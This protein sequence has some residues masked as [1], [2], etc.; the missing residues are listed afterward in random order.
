MLALVGHEVLLRVRDER[1]MLLEDRARGR[2]RHRRA[3][4]ARRRR[5]RRG[6]RHR[7]RRQPR[8]RPSPGCNRARPLVQM[9]LQPVRV[10]VAL[11]A[12]GDRALVPLL[13]RAT[14][15]LALPPASTGR[16]RR[17]RRGLFRLLRL[18]H[19]LPD[20][21]GVEDRELR[22]EPLF[23]RRRAR[24]EQVRR[25]GGPGARRGR[26]R[27][28]LRRRLGRLGAHDARGAAA[29]GRGARRRRAAHAAGGGDDVV[30]VAAAPAPRG[31]EPRRRRGC[32]EER[33]GQADLRLLGGAERA[34]GVHGGG[35][36]ARDVRVRGVRG[37]AD[38]RRVV[39][40]VEV[41][42]H[43]V[44]VDRAARA[45]QCRAARDTAEGVCARERV[46]VRADADAAGGGVHGERGERGVCGER[47]GGRAPA[48][49]GRHAERV[50]RRR[51]GQRGAEAVVRARHLLLLLLHRRVH[52]HVHLGDL[53]RSLRVVRGR[54]RQ[55]RRQLGRRGVDVLHAERRL[56]LLLLLRVRRCGLVILHLSLWRHRHLHL[57]LLL[58][59]LRLDLGV[60][61]L[62]RL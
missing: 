31:G 28:V 39:E 32:G 53:Q 50:L 35:D 33:G 59:H 57:V 62:R 54:G 40:R 58:H 18:A 17:G 8:P 1:V 3:H 25:E 44:L 47:D 52:L 14:P 30:E 29:G 48:H 7:R 45:A 15:A 24:D 51:S 27:A 46:R 11:R 60:V 49:D 13:A 5:H 34:P 43:V 16:R 10:Q 6:R 41:H 42:Q 21:Q 9:V 56:L 19:A 22:F 12:P 61:G 55:A 4:H 36:G 26:G 23:L 20:R 38:E 2:A 37:V